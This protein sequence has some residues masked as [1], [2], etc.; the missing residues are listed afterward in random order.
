MN[1]STAI[2]YCQARGMQLY[3]VLTDLDYD[4][5]EN[6]AGK[7]F[8]TSGGTVLI[9]GIQAPNGT[10]ITA[11]SNPKRLYSAVQIA[12][13]SACLGLNV[14]PSYKMNPRAIPCNSAVNSYC[15]FY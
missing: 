8:P 10:W 2:S 6:L 15:E 12:G 13:S 9:N 14:G 4:L 3:S 7:T 11:D 1:I 5:L